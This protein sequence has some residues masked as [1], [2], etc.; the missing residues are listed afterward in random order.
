MNPKSAPFNN[1]NTSQVMTIACF[2]IVDHSFC[3]NVA[4]AWLIF[5][6]DVLLIILQLY[7]N[8]M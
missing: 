7:Q 1:A 5:S 2:S 6:C 3:D 8:Y 4:A